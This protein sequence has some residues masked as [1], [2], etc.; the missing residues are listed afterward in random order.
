MSDLSVVGIRTT[1]GPW[2][3]GR[4]ALATAVTAGMITMK[5][6]AIDADVHRRNALT[7]FSFLN[8]S[9]PP[10]SRVVSVNDL[11]RDGA[12]LA[13]SDHGGEALHSGFFSTISLFSGRY[14]LGE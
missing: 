7:D 5:T 1:E 14:L 6:V 11:H 8:M 9:G 10:S 4:A 12:E 3:F 13:I 2:P